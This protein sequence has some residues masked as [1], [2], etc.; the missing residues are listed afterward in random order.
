MA[1]LRP[2]KRL[3]A[4]ELDP[5][6]LRVWLAYMRVNLQLTYEMNHQLLAESE[7]SLSDYHVLSKLHQ[8]PDQ[9]LRIAPLARE[10]GWERSRTSHQVR[11]MGQRGLIGTGPVKDDRRGTEVTVTNRGKAAFRDARQ[12]HVALVRELFFRGLPEEVLLPLAETLEHVY[13]NI[14]ERGSGYRGADD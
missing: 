11:R 13:T 4:T 10:I 8:A 1:K 14:V 3:T 6:Q 12:G 9:R 2:N 7:L 5:E